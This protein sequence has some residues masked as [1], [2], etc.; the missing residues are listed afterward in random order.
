MVLPCYTP[1]KTSSSFPG[2][3][4]LMNAI[5]LLPDMIPPTGHRKGLAQLHSG[6][7][8]SSVI[9]T[10]ALLLPDLK[11]VDRRPMPYAHPCHQHIT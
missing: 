10:Q 1:V 3:R 5:S 2:N 6:L 11:L 8:E 4:Y 7:L 9:G